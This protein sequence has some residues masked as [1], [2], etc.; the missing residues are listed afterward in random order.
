MIKSNSL[1]IPTSILSLPECLHAL[2]YHTLTLLWFHICAQKDLKNQ[3]QVKLSIVHCPPVT[4]AIIKR[5]DP[6]YQLGFSVED[7]IVSIFSFFKYVLSV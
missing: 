7:G 3:A 4:M 2:K 1:L 6:K 5:P